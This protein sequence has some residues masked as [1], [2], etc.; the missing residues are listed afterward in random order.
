[1]D[2]CDAAGISNYPF[3][4]LYRILF[5]YSLKYGYDEIAGGFY[6]SGLFNQPADSLTKVWWVEAEAVVSALYMHRFSGDPQYLDIFQQTYDYIEKQLV[7][8][9]HGE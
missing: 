5:D 3:G 4:D 6:D 9:E 1:M 7:D 2:A 8:F